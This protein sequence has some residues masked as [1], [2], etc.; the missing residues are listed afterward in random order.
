MTSVVDEMTGNVNGMEKMI[1]KLRMMIVTL[2]CI[3]FILQ[4]IV[5]MLVVVVKE[6]MP[7]QKAKNDE[8]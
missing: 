2:L 6:Q 7:W 4:F 5:I 1:K 8:C 3:Q